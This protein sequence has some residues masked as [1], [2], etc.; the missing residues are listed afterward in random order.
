MVEAKRFE[1][2]L[3]CKKGVLNSKIKLLKNRLVHKNAMR[4]GIP[5][6]YATSQNSAKKGVPCRFIL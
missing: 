2:V 4:N 5:P 6:G 3:I 1:G